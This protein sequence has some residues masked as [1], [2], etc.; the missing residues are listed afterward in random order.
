M[1]RR[2]E[3]EEPKWVGT[4]QQNGN[5]HATRPLPA[6]EQ[7]S[8]GSCARCAGLLVNDWCYDL[9]NTDEYHAKILRCVQCG[10]RIDP[11]ILRNQALSRVESA[12]GR[13]TYVLREIG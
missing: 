8:A 10:H 1:E 7:F 13:C 4:M 12:S 5:G 9:A 6:S 2:M 11:V 3:L